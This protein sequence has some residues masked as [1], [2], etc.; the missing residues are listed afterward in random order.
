MDKIDLEILAL[1]NRYFNWIQ[2]NN[3]KDNIDNYIYYFQ[4]VEK[5]KNVYGVQPHSHQAKKIL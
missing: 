2:K 4:H 1:F 3:F 5:I